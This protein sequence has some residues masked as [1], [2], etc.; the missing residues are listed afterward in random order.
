ML[1]KWF[2]QS[3]L[4][5]SFFLPI[6]AKRFVTHDPRKVCLMKQTRNKPFWYTILAKTCWEVILAKNM[7]LLHPRKKNLQATIL[8]KLLQ[9]S[10]LA[11]KQPSSQKS[12]QG[13][14]LA[15][16]FTLSSQRKFILAK[17]HWCSQQNFQKWSSQIN[18]WSSQQL[19]LAK[20]G[21]RKNQCSQKF[22]WCSQNPSLI[23]KLAKISDEHKIKLAKWKI[24]TNARKNALNFWTEAFKTEISREF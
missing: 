14:I 8:A 21:A 16:I 19:M 23:P 12:L 18:A 20:F 3:K 11:S 22:C 2:C 24:K 10:I 9:A 13:T 17:K 6:L 15:K 5:K 1:E 4:A 7:L